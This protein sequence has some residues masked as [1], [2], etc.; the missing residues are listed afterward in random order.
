MVVAL[1]TIARAVYGI[2][3]GF[4]HA[5]AFAAA[6]GEQLWPAQILEPRSC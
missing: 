5:E 2:P 6:N 3:A 4:F 1:T